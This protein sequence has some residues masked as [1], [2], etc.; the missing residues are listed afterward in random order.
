MR[1]SFHSRADWA[2]VTALVSTL[3]A[4]NASAQQPTITLADAIAM[5]QKVQPTTVQAQGAISNANSQ[6]LTA[7]GA[8]LPNL[9]AFSSYGPSF[10]SGPA[11]TNPVTGELTSGNTKVTSLSTGLSAS[12]DLFTG[13]RRNADLKTAHANQDAAQAGMVQASFQVALVT[14]QTFLDA[15]AASQLLRVR[16][17]EVTRATEQLNVSIAKLKAGSATRSDS[18]RSLVTLGNARLDSVAASTQLATAEAT[19]G[20]L[21]GARGRV[22]AADDSAFYRVAAEIDSVALEQEAE[23]QSPAVRN[24]AA[25]AKAAHASVGSAKA[26]YWPTLTLSGSASWNGSSTNDYT[27]FNQRQLNLGLSWPLFSRF[28]R[29]QTINTRDNAAELA[30]AVA[31]DATR[32]V[33]SSL[34]AQLANLRAAE[35]RMQITA[36]SVQAAQED[37]RV[38]QDRYRVGSSTIVDVLLS[39]EALTQAEVDVVNARFDYLRAKAQIEALIGRPL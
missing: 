31:A 12:I 27:L 28:S 34:T 36:T 32:Q 25:L 37:L 17:V 6:T 16:Q 20:Q 7:K 11:R 35:V 30:D 2:L 23:D 19:L 33:S 9:N 26:A 13:L 39:Q 38:Q 3:A 15:L 18:L 4:G 8:F 10:S 22:T 5:A 29:E 1:R 24:A 21:I 14:T